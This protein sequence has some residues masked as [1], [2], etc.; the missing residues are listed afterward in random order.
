MLKKLL[1]L[2]LICTFSGVSAVAQ[3]V[4]QLAS[5]ATSAGIVTALLVSSTG[6]VTLG[7]AGVA[8]QTRPPGQLISGAT[9]TG[10][11]VPLLVDAAGG[12][13]TSNGM[14]GTCANTQVLYGTGTS[15]FACAATLSWAS[16]AL[17]IGVA[18]SSTGQ[19]KL[20]GATSGTVTLTPATIAGTWT[21][22]LPATSGTSGYVLTTDGTGV[23]SWAAS[24]SISGLTTNYLPRAASASTL[25][26][27]G[28]QVSGSD[29][30]FGS[31]APTA[32]TRVQIK[33]NGDSDFTTGLYIR[34]GTTGGGTG[35]AMKIDDPTGTQLF[36]ISYN[37]IIFGNS[38]TTINPATGDISAGDGTNAQVINLGG[39]QGGIDK[40]A[41]TIDMYA[42]GT[43]DLTLYTASTSHT[44]II[45]TSG[46]K[47]SMGGT[48]T[49]STNITTA[50]GTPGSLCYN[51]GTFEML[52]NNALT[53]TVSARDQKH[54][55]FTLVD[56]GFDKL[57]PVEFRYNDHDERVRWGFIADEVQAVNHALGD[58][59]ND[60]D[61]ARSIDT[62]AILALTVKELQEARRRI[63]T[64]ESRIQ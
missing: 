56:G 55:I 49:L 57:R 40:T 58:A 61:E 47:T 7:G 35:T 38:K 32:N 60:N 50:T 44:V 62:N 28:V 21:M 42:S 10:V 2:C 36:K 24:S 16:P 26:D 54:G 45:Q 34:A 43:A 13:V 48:V 31:V 53:C 8:G 19:L 9:S 30:S 51:T 33:A 39:G 17:T 63:A 5:G 37:S 22:Q 41:S 25:A 20:T 14:S 11:V 52:K 46:G 59:Y 29:V 1:I 64:L 27:S 12:L 18:G 23:T 6:A 4:G 15:T 3:D